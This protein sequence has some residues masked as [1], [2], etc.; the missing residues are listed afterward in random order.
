MHCARVCCTA[1]FLSCLLALPAAQAASASTE[2]LSDMSLE[3]LMNIEVTSVSKRAQRKSEAAAAIFVITNE[4]LRRWGVTNIPDALRRVP[5]LQVARIDANKWAITARGFNSRFANKLLVLIDGRSVY[6]PLFAG[7]YWEANDVMLEDVARIEVIRGPGGTLWG[8]N[9]VN[10]VI[11]IITKSSSETQGTLL[12]GGAGNEEKGL[13]NLRHGGSTP[14][15]GNYRLYGKFHGVDTGEPIGFG[16]PTAAHDDSEF[17]QGGFRT[18]WDSGNS[19]SFSLQGD[20]YN[21]HADQQLLLATSATPV[22]DNADY[23]GNNLLYRWLHRNSERSSFT[24]QAYYDYVGLDSAVLYED[25]RT[26]D[27]DFQ[28]HYTTSG[29]HDLVWGLNYRNISDDTESRPTFSLTPAK[30]TV[31]LYTAFIQDEISLLDDHAQLT[32]GSKFEQNDFTGFEAQPNIRLAWH[33]ESGATLWGAVSRAVRTPARGEHDVTLAVIPPPPAPPPLT[34]FGNEQFNSED[35]IAYEL[36]YR[37]KPTER[38]SVDLA[39]FYN[40]YKQLRTVEITSMPPGAFE[41]TFGNNMEGNT[42]GLEIDAHWQTSPWLSVNANYTRLEIDLDLTNNSGDTLSLSAEDASPTHQANLWMA[43]DLDHGID[44]DAGLRYVDTIHTPGMP[45]S[46]PSYLA[47]DARIGWQP[48]PGL[49]LSLIGQNLFDDSHPE[50]NPDFIF[51][52]PTE[53]ERSIY[54]KVTLKF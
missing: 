9:A 7:V 34:I 45:A 3:A 17:G 44:L 41:A 43:A 53:V 50:F 20:A 47:F 51:S 31:N 25:R 11:N 15:G 48:R 22:I 40:S 32:I 13:I 42:Q 35:L 4:D 46:T 33:T 24:L 5:G 26:L 8:A 16:F 29:T 18:D 37:F 21:G 39:A 6:T 52:L 28:H 38:L 10:G 14:G 1:G 49:E 30:R 36:G 2:D 19:D 23:E 12:A 54:G 27:L